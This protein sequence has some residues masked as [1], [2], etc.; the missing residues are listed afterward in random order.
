MNGLVQI[1]VT[2]APVPPRRGDGQS[3]FFD[4]EWQASEFVS[5]MIKIG[6]DT[7]RIKTVRHFDN[8]DQKL[9]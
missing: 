9:H 6:V 7:A 4:V 1:V 2:V 5:K 8:N 3:F